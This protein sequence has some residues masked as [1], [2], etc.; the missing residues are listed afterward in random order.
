MAEGLLAKKS[1]GLAGAAVFS[2]LAALSTL[3]IPAKIQPAFIPLPFLLFDLAE[4]FVV[5]AFLNFGPIPA[6][7]VATVH[8]TS[9]VVND[10]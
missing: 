2:S 1:V 10:R 5:L 4:I 3:I 9:G 7:I 8:Q 6:F